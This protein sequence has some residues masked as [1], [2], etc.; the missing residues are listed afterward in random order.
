MAAKPYAF[1]NWP[2][3]FRVTFG[4]YRAVVDRHMDAD[5]ILC[6]VDLGMGE[7]VPKEIRMLKY[8]SPESYTQEGKDALL[9]GQ[10]LL[11]RD[12]RVILHAEKTDFDPSFSRWAAS[13]EMYPSGYYE[14]R[15]YHAGHAKEGK[16][17]G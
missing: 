16:F 13:I 2:K 12:S 11:P 15:M 8:S 9:Y 14:S 4:P 1:Q 17:K 5:T 3:N 10:G 6:Q 7:Y